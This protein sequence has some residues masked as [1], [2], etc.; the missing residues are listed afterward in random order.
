MKKLL[1]LVT[2]IALAGCAAPRTSI[3]TANVSGT[4]LFKVKPS[5]AEISIDGNV[6]GKARDFDG[7]SNVAKVGPGKHVVLVSAPGY[8]SWESR[9]YLSDTQEKVEVDLQ[10]AG[11]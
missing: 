5:S 4:M 10:K 3:E 6:I 11:N 7:S 8:V 1:S 2:L 9:V